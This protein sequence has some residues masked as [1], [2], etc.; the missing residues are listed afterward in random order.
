MREEYPV[1]LPD[2]L[3]SGEDLFGTIQI[4]KGK[5]IKKGILEIDY[6]FNF[7]EKFSYPVV[8]E[9]K[10]ID[11]EIVI[12]HIAF[13]VWGERYAKQRMIEENITIPGVIRTLRHKDF[14]HFFAEVVRKDIDF[15]LYLDEIPKKFI[16]VKFHPLQ[17]G[18]RIVLNEQLIMEILHCLDTK[19]STV[20]NIRNSSNLNQ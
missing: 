6:N 19:T 10:T 9:F 12:D 2:W 8:F 17:A 20:E 14:I 3:G 16:G 5:N 18:Q 4:M 1:E 15:A 11:N 13:R 7:S